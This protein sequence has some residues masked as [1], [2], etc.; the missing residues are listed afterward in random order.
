MEMKRCGKK[1]RR[2]YGRKKEI[3]REKR[4][5]EREEKDRMKK[6]KKESYREKYTIK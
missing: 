1:L 6:I 4:K 2:K 5:I 3:I